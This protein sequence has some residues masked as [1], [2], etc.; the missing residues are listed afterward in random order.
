MRTATSRACWSSRS[1][2]MK[3]LRVLGEALRHRREPRSDAG[4]RRPHAA[5]PRQPHASR[6]GR[7]LALAGDEGNAEAHIALGEVLQETDRFPD[8]LACLRSRGHAR[9]QLLRGAQHLRHLPQVGRPPRGRRMRNSSRRWRSIPSPMAPI[10]T[11]PISSV[12]RRTIRH[13][14]AMEAIVEKAEDLSSP[15][16]LSLNFALGK[17]YDDLANTRRQSVTTRSGQS[18]SARRSSTTRPR[19]GLLRRDPGDLQPGVL[20]QPALCRQPIIRADLHRRHAAIR[21]D[22]GRADPLRAIR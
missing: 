3:A 19:G 17:A 14:L 9:P 2:A 7:R 16:Y 6:A 18:P 15:R 21:L 4:H 11:L 8:A 5:Q 20:R 10:P 22:P 13:L 1:V 12:S